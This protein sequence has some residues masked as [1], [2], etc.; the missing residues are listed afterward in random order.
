MTTKEKEEYLD[1]KRSKTVQDGIDRSRVKIHYDMQ[2][3]LHY[4]Y[5]KAIRLAKRKFIEAQPPSGSED[6]KKVQY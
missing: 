3:A 5:I 4:S 2:I 1:G 6:N